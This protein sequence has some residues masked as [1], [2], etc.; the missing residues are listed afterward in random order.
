MAAVGE[1]GLHRRC[2]AVDHA[3][4]HQ[5]DAGYAQPRP[6]QPP[7]QFHGPPDLPQVVLGAAGPFDQPVP[8]H[9][10]LRPWIRGARFIDGAI[11][12]GRRAAAELP[13]ALT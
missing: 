10:Q 1:R 6:G 2:A 8:G 11:D 12:S 13:A 5:L 7:G 4:H 9:P 3:V